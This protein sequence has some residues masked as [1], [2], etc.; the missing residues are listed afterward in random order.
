MEV[1]YKRKTLLY[2][3]KPNGWGTQYELY[4]IKP[5]CDKLKPHLTGYKRLY[6]SH[7]TCFRFGPMTPAVLISAGTTPDKIFEIK[8]CPLCGKRITFHEVSHKT[9]EQVERIVVQ[10]SENRV[11]EWMEVTEGGGG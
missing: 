4:E 9:Y 11:R 5:C 8:Y 1:Y 2:S 7:F 6:F 10:Q 3:K